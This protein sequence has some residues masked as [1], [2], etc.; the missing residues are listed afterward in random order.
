MLSKTDKKSLEFIPALMPAKAFVITFL[1]KGK[2]GSVLSM[3]VVHD[4][5]QKAIACLKRHSQVATVKS[6]VQEYVYLPGKF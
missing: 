4:T 5:K 3:R 2:D 6:V 1:T